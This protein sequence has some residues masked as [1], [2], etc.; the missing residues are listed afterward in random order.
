MR[1]TYVG[2]G[3][4]LP[5]FRA[6]EATLDALQA[7]FHNEMD[8]KQFAKFAGELVQQSFD[9]W[10]TRTYDCYQKCCLGIQ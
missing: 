1:A 4:Q 9:H 2:V 7:R 6:G 3:G 10:R 8:E 5:C